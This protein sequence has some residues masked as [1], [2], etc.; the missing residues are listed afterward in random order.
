MARVVV[1][2][3]HQG[4]LSYGYVRGGK[5]GDGYVTTGLSAHCRWFMHNCYLLQ[6]PKIIGY[7]RKDGKGN[8]KSKNWEKNSND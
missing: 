4:W 7:D 2:G 1:G 5:E 6:F 8:E 3:G